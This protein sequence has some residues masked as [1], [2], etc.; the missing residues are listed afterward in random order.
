MRDYRQTLIT[1]VNVSLVFDAGNLLILLYN[2]TLLNIKNYVE[3]D[4]D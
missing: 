2:L 4:V 1:Y 3:T